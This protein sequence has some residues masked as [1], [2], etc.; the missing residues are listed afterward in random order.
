MKQLDEMRA[1]LLRAYETSRVQLVELESVLA[2]R[3]RDLRDAESR[4][5]VIEGLIRRFELLARHYESDMERLA[6]VEETGSMLATLPTSACPV[7]GAAPEDHRPEEAAEHFRAG[8]V[9]E[10]ARSEQEKIGRLRTDLQRTL[11]E[12][13]RDAETQSVTRLLVQAEAQALQEQIAGEVQPRVRTSIEKLQTQNDR[14]DAL[15]RGR[16]LTDQLRELRLRAEELEAPGKRDKGR[17]TSGATGPTTAGVDAFALGVQEILREWHFPETGRVVFSEDS[18]DLVVGGQP[19]VSHGKGVRALSCSAFIAG[20]MRHCLQRG[21]PHPGLI[22]LDSPLV[23]Y[24]DPD[25]SAGA[26]STLIRQ[27]G[28]KEAFYRALADGFCLGQVIVLENE[29]PPSDVADRVSHY[30]FTKGAS[31]RY[32]LFPLA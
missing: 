13:S 30:H 25:S 2:A 18:Q 10:A 28:V 9:R 21:L 5:V 14:R 32:G 17:G 26:D 27:A 3:S 19:R 20:V 31:G 11:Y 15:L 1:D 6:A 29:A 16:V 23:A 24:K 7:C 12:L 4:L 8:D 22:V